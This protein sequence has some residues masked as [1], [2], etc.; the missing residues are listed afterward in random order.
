MSDAQVTID[1]CTTGG[2]VTVSVEVSNLRHA[3]MDDNWGTANVRRA[4]SRRGMRRGSL[5]S[6]RLCLRV[7]TCICMSVPSLRCQRVH[8]LPDGAASSAPSRVDRR[9]HTA[10]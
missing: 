5:L 6:P 1:A 3:W 10:V 2:E 7:Q 9:M 4:V 8:G